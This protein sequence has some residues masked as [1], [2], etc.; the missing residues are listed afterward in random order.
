VSRRFLITLW[1]FTGHLLPQL[2]IAAR[3]EVGLRE[4]VQLATTMRRAGRAATVLM[5]SQFVAR[6]REDLLPAG[7]FAY[8]PAVRARST[9]SGGE[10]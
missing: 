10:G 9:T 4:L 5:P 1:P 2:R 7:L 3:T 8:H 6:R